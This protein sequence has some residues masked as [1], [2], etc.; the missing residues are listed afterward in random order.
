MGVNTLKNF[1]VPKVRG[2]GVPK[3]GQIMNFYV[4]LIWRASVIRIN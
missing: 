3:L 1:Y 4:I 2:N